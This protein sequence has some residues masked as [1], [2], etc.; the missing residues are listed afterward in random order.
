MATVSLSG[1]RGEPLSDGEKNHRRFL[2]KT[3][4]VLGEKHRA[5]LDYTS[6][7]QSFREACLAATGEQ[8]DA[9]GEIEVDPKT[10]TLF[11]NA[12]K[13]LYEELVRKDKGELIPLRL[14]ARCQKSANLLTPLFEATYEEPAV[15]GREK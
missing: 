11:L 1:C 2:D 13:T 15:A 10:E 14:D 12:K 6:A 8:T 7:Q 4:A 3:A 9:E 5:I